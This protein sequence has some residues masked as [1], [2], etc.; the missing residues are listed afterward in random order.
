MFRAKKTKVIGVLTTCA[1]LITALV[2]LGC[3]SIKPEEVYAAGAAGGTISYGGSG[4]GSCTKGFTW[5]GGGQHECIGAAWM[6]FNVGTKPSGDPGKNQYNLDKP[7]LEDVDAKCKDYGSYYRL[8]LARFEAQNGKFV[9]FKDHQLAYFKQ[10]KQVEPSGGIRYR[11]DAPGAEVFDSVRQDFERAKKHWSD[12]KAAGVKLDADT[13]EF[14]NQSWEDTSWF[15]WNEDLYNGSATSTF[16][17]WST[18]V[19]KDSSGATKLTV[20][21]KT[22]DSSRTGTLK[23]KEDTITIDFKHRFNYEKPTSGSGKFDPAITK[24]GVQVSG[25]ANQTVVPAGTEYKVADSGPDRTIGPL[26][27]NLVGESTQTITVPDSGSTTV[28]SKISYDPKVI[29]WKS[30]QGGGFEMDPATTKNMGKSSEAC[31]VIERVEEDEEEPE[32]GGQINFW[33]SSKVSAAG[34]YDGADYLPSGAYVEVNDKDENDIGKTGTLVL[35]I[36]AKSIEV[37]F[38][39]KMYKFHSQTDNPTVAMD[40]E[41][42]TKEDEWPDDV[43]TEYTITMADGSTDGGEYCHATGN[44]INENEKEVKKYTH[45]VK[46]PNVDKVERVCSKITYN[47]RTI[48]LERIRNTHQEETGN[49]LYISSYTGQAAYAYDDFWGDYFAVGA[50]YDPWGNDVIVLYYDSEGNPVYSWNGPVYYID[51]GNPADP[52]D[53]IWYSLYEKEYK[54][55]FDNYTYSVKDDDGVTGGTEACVEVIRPADPDQPGSGGVKGPNQG[56][57]APDRTYVGETTGMSWDLKAKYYNVRRITAYQ[58]ILFQVHVNQDNGSDITKG[59]IAS[60]GEQG[61]PRSNIDPCSW[62]GSGKR[63]IQLRNG[64]CAVA[65]SAG[66]Q[67]ASSGI[68]GEV[69]SE[70]GVEWSTKTSQTYAVPE[71]VG[72]KYCNSAGLQ[73]GKWYGKR[74]GNSKASYFSYGSPY[75]T[76]YD[77][78]CRTIVKKPTTAFWNGGVFTPKDVITSLAPRH[79]NGGFNMLANST[80]VRNFGS[81]T[82]YLGVIGGTVTQ[83]S[84][85]GGLAFNGTGNSF[86]MAQ[87]SMLTIANAGGSYGDSGVKVTSTLRDRLKTY[88]LSGDMEPDTSTSTIAGG[89]FSTGT[90]VYNVSGDATITGDI[91]LSPAKN[92]TIYDLPQVIIYATGNINIRSDVSRIDAWLITDGGV[93]N[94][95]AESD[96]PNKLE[97]YVND[98]DHTSTTCA[99]QLIINGPVIAKGVK[100]NRTAGADI[101]NYQP[102]TSGKLF[103][104]SYWEG[105]EVYPNGNLRTVT[106]EVFNL[107]ASSYLW[108]YAQAGRYDSSYTEAYTREL[109]PRY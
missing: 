85:G 1:T 64:L 94:T 28:C 30:K 90:K 70:T 96:I 31:V 62:Y 97:A 17:A 55:V 32:D 74:E 8:G 2:V 4:G 81:W 52:W 63:H 34:K 13:E 26:E 24:Y 86:N 73:W 10:V 99:K 43:C 27:P 105:G 37:E 6:K 58:P 68:M 101:L 42:G 60:A 106:G 79:N 9:S 33:S 95:C 16:G 45:T 69:G 72:D 77:A 36:D 107:S 15:C 12:Q 22:I 59:N 44:K 25:A 49:Y 51:W 56:D 84:T 5:T 102:N 41:K 103:S 47:P 89:T 75:W 46:V 78:A 7:N 3:A 93:V 66:G 104:N 53:D 87:N 48:Y 88:L 40:G 80:P 109:P 76:N 61:T 57:A 83:F 11:A 38:T 91:I 98:Y 65:D 71:H 20:N 92:S 39:H 100:L 50:V 108:G 82:E 14:L 54:E 21:T 35:G 67:S 23:T 29:G 18:A 19:A